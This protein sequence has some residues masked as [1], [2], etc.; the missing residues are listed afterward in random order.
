MV[1]K[2]SFAI[3]I[4][5]FYPRLDKCHSRSQI[6]PVAFRRFW[7]FLTFGVISWASFSWKNVPLGFGR[8]PKA[9]QK[10]L[11]K[12]KGTFFRENECAKWYQNFGNV[13]ICGRQQGIFVIVCGICRGVDKKQLSKWHNWQKTR[14]Y[15]TKIKPALEAG[16]GCCSAAAAAAAAAATA[17]ACTLMCFLHWSP[18]LKVL[19]Q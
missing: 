3:W 5:G 14:K 4:F 10:A 13:K 18:V 16:A 12:S 8:A 9:S 19:L 2:A 17:G 1:F 15:C 6:F 7:Q 11:S